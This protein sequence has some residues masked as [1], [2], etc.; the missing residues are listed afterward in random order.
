[1]HDLCCFF[2]SSD[3]AK[4]LFVKAIAGDAMAAA[5][6]RCDIKWRRVMPE[7]QLQRFMS[8]SDR[9]HECHFKPGVATPGLQADRN[10]LMIQNKLPVFSTTQNTSCSA[11]T[12]SPFRATSNSLAQSISVLARL[13]RKRGH[14]QY[15]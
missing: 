14:K 3:L 10:H 4:M 12:G 5:P 11:P 8:F 1:M 2:R 13:A 7:G 9:S 6:A 15:D